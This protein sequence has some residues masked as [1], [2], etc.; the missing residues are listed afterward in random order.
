[1]ALSLRGLSQ[2]QDISALN[3]RKGEFT[4]R[5]RVAEAR[6][7][8]T[9]FGVVISLVVILGL[10]NFLLGYFN[11]RAEDRK[12][13]EQMRQIFFSTFPET[14]QLPAG[15]ELREMRNRI[16]ALQGNGEFSTGSETVVDL[17][18]IISERIPEDVNVEIREM[19]YDPEKIRLRGRT[20]SFDT[21]DRIKTELTGSPAWSSIEV[22]E[23][24]VSIDQKGVDFTMVINLVKKI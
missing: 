5:S 19:I 24:K 20:T 15:Y 2:A 14:T 3:F 22:T 6:G 18:K 9:Y 1:V 17:L 4:F 23:A 11:R 12:L 7:R 8:L 16:Q 10:G 21:V 13:T